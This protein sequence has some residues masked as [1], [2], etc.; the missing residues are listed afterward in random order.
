MRRSTP[1]MAVCSPIPHGMLAVALVLALAASVGAVVDS[2]LTSPLQ[3]QATQRP[4]YDRETITVKFRSDVG[5]DRVADVVTELGCAI[6]KRSVYTPGLS[7]VAIPAGDGIG[8][9]IDTF[10]QRRDVEYA[11][12]SY[13]DYAAFIPNDPQY[14]SQ[15]HFPMIGMPEAWEKVPSRG[16]ASVV[17]C[18]LDTGV[19]YED[20]GSNYIIAPDL[21]GVTF[22]HPRDF[23]NDDYHANDDHHHGTHVCGT[24]AQRTN[25]SRGVAGMADGVSIMPVKVLDATG[26]GSGDHVAFSDGVHWAINHGADIINYSA[27]GGHS[28]TKYQAVKDAYDGGVLLIA[29]AGNTVPSG[30]DALDYPAGYSEAMAV[31]AVDRKRNLAYY[32]NYGTGLDVSAPG[33]ET[34]VNLSDGVLQNTFPYQQPRNM[35]YYYFQGTSMA[36]PHVTGLAAL[37]MTQGTYTSRAQVKSRIE[38]TC[39]DLGATGYDTRFGNGLIDAEAAIPAAGRPPTLEW[40]GLSGY[41]TDGYEP[42][43]GYPVGDPNETR[44]YFKV[45]YKDP[46]GDI[47]TRAQCI[48]QRRLCD[49]T[50]QRART[51]TMT[52]A[53][54]GSYVNGKIYRASAKLPNEVYQYKFYFRAADG[55]ATG[56][57]TKYQQGP[58]IIAAPQLCW[59]GQTGYASDGVE[60][61]SGPTVTRFVFKVKY[62]DSC[63]DAPTT[64]QLKLKRYDTVYK[65][66]S[67]GKQSGDP[68]HGAIYVASFTIRR[69]GVYSYRFRF[70]D[71]TGPATGVPSQWTAG[72]TL[73]GTS[74]AG[75]VTSVSAQPTNAGV[76]LTFSLSANAAVTA[77]VMNVAGRPV[78]T[79]VVDK[80]LAAGLNTLLWDR[81]SSTGLPVPAGLYVICVQARHDDGQSSAAIATVS[82]R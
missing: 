38:S 3:V 9:W 23:I 56:L 78:R 19:A 63:G 17:V 82:L 44:F 5:R 4:V 35:G 61:N 70:A 14:G 72:P 47:P 24:I 69:T 25:N 51:L 15:W 66:L 55:L 73:E 33:G 42:P 59:A 26:A 36:T 16:S 75:P 20:Y 27:G 8:E 54:G 48:I 39:E 11:E 2:P 43:Q 41:T 46:D 49:G 65:T 6:R 10:N 68:R 30:V 52:P 76:Q 22:V 12:P 28:N 80:P 74:G 45:K 34:N 21:S 64:T 50:W 13:Y 58:L 60:P 31:A 62:M 1:R 18:V 40:A 53:D 37:L 77:T 79:I 71:G 29:A 7:V 57:P 32:S 67:M 81:R